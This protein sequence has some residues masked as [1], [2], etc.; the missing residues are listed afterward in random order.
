MIMRFARFTV[1]VILAA[2]A[3]GAACASTD[4]DFLAARDAF[5]A[6]D[7]RKLDAFAKRLHGYVLEP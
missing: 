1:L 5:R 6:G 2:F 7:A 3:A 4:D